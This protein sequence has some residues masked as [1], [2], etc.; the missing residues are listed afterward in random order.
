MKLEDWLRFEDVVW[1]VAL[2]GA[3]LFEPC[4]WFGAVSVNYVSFGLSKRSF[5]PCN[6]THETM[7]LN[8]CV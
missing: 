8:H 1:Q 7:S 3:I 4:I 6:G 2:N 5:L